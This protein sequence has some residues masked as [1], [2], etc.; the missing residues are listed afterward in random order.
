MADKPPTS[1]SRVGRPRTKSVH[2]TPCAPLGKPKAGRLR[3][4]SSHPSK[5]TDSS[6]KKCKVNFVEVLK[7]ENIR[8]QSEYI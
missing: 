3:S 4:K 8:V 5:V 7:N 2:Q 6:K 1:T